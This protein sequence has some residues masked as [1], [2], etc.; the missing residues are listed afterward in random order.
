MSN[1]F[2]YCTVYTVQL[3]AWKENFVWTELNCFEKLDPVQKKGPN[4]QQTQSKT[5]PDLKKWE[6]FCFAIAKHVKRRHSAE[7]NQSFFSTGPQQSFHTGQIRGNRFQKRIL[8]QLGWDSYRTPSPPPLPPNQNWNI[9]ED[10]TQKKLDF[11]RTIY[12]K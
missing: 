10:A 5:E 11:C 6:T 4:R 8:Y 7:S 12:S 1:I 2:I 9:L 3:I